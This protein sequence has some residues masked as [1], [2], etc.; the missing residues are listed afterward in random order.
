MMSSKPTAPEVV[1]DWSRLLGFD[2]ATRDEGQAA[3]SGLNDPRLV[4]LGAKF[5]RKLGGKRPAIVDVTLAR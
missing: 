1:L 4:K 2:Q 5:G 3:A